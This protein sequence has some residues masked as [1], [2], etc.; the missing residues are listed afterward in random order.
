[1]ETSWCKLTS[2]FAFW[3]LCCAESLS[4]V[5]LFVTPW[6]VARQAPL[7]MGIPQ[8]RYWSGLPCPPQ[9]IFPTQGS[10]PGILHCGFPHSSVGNK[11]ACNAGDPGPV[12]GWGRSAAEGIGYPLQY[13][14]ASLVAQLVK[15]PPAMWESWV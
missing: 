9:G 11:L 4:R 3:L 2:Q 5:R 14:W 15:N 8:A 10:N 13:S 12:P 6:T 1:M 7:S